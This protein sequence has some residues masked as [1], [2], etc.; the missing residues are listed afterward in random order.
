MKMKKWGLLC[1]GLATAGV[2][3]TGLPG[4]PANVAEAM[5]SAVDAQHHWYKVMN[6][7]QKVFLL[8]AARGDYNTVCD[9]LNS[10]VDINGVYKDGSY[11]DGTTAML[12]AIRNGQRG[13]MQLLLENGADVNGFTT[14]DG[15][16]RSYLVYSLQCK[17]SLEEV[18]YLHNWGAD[19]NRVH[20]RRDNGIGNALSY[21]VWYGDRNDNTLNIVY[22]LVEQGI[23][24]E[25]MDKDGDTPFI[26]AV[27]RE[28]FPLIDYLADHGSDVYVKD[29]H[30][31][32]GTEIALARNKLD[33]Y[34]H[35]KWLMERGNQPSNY[36]PPAGA[37]ISGSAA[38]AKV[39]RGTSLGKFVDTY[40]KYS[41]ASDKIY[42]ELDA[43]LADTSTGVTKEKLSK[44]NDAIK[45]LKKLNEKMAKEDPL[46]GFKGYSVGER[47]KFTD[48]FDGLTEYNDA[49]IALLEYVVVHPT[50]GDHDQLVNLTAQV[51]KAQGYQKDRLAA[52]QEIIQ[53]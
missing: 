24:I 48:L 45:Q 21:I 42:N 31:K 30:G 2:L 33:L 8:A 15:T 6:E 37:G 49:M 34:K 5:Y 7:Q 29:Y 17:Q 28:W 9:M 10:G 19:L 3:V 52:V 46:K 13:I 36:T 18:Q 47:E 38:Q 20:T 26:D 43:A 41:D 27:K 23:N 51:I 12:V 53:K 44:E 25:E 16:Y 32:T 11:D 35:L 22:Y 40:K 14:F 39:D 50:D 1:A 4:E